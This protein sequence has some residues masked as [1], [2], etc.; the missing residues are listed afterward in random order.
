M[1]Q[2]LVGGIGVFIRDT[3]E[4]TQSFTMKEH[5]GSMSSMRK[6]LSARLPMAGSGYQLS[7]MTYDL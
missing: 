5:S 3:M 7:P 6:S 4:F 1:G 2:E